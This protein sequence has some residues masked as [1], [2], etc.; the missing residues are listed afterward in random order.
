MQEKNDDITVE[1]DIVRNAQDMADA[2]QIRREEFVNKQN[3]PTE[4]EFDG[5]EYTGTTLLAKIDG[6]PAGTLRIRY[7]RD[8]IRFERMCVIEKYRKTELCDK[9]LSYSANF[10]ASKGFDTAYCLCEEPLLQH[11]LEKDHK[12]VQGVDPVIVHGKKLIPIYIKFPNGA[13]NFN[14][15][16]DPNR[17]IA[18]EGKKATYQIKAPQQNIQDRI[19]VL[20][21]KKYQR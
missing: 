20:Y 9:M 13:E 7:F 3:I 11:W 5:N 1:I 2:L 16:E 21:A 18:Q 15:W 17:L 14:F 19:G 8:T 6:K 10:L 4:I 12:L